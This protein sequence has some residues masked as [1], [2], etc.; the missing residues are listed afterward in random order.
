[1]NHQHKT[2]VSE[3]EFFSLREVEQFLSNQ[4]PANHLTLQYLLRCITAK[5]CGL[6]FPYSGALQIRFDPLSEISDNQSRYSYSGH[7]EILDYKYGAERDGY[8]VTAEVRPYDLNSLIPRKGSFTV[9]ELTNRSDYHFYP[10]LEHSHPTCNQ[11]N[12]CR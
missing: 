4:L 10:L 5:K 2:Q 6:Y 12:C 8:F 11:L 3:D 1:M 7:L 9:S